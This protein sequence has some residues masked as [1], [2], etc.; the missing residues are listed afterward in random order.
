MPGCGRAGLYAGGKNGHGRWE[1]LHLG[2]ASPG[3][4]LP[5]LHLCSP[6]MRRRWACF[7]SSPSCEPPPARRLL[8]PL[9]MPPGPPLALNAATSLNTIVQDSQRTT[10][11]GAGSGASSCAPIAVTSPSREWRREAGGLVCARLQRM[12]GLFRA[13]KQTEIIAPPFSIHYGHR[14]R[15]EKVLRKIVLSLAQNQGCK[16]LLLFLRVPR[17]ERSACSIAVRCREP[18][19]WEVHARGQCHVVVWTLLRVTTFQ[20]IASVANS[21]RVYESKRLSHKRAARASV[22]HVALALHRSA[23]SGTA[24][25][26]RGFNNVVGLSRLRSVETPSSSHQL[27][28]RPPDVRSSSLFVCV[29]LCVCVCVHARVSGQAWSASSMACRRT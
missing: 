21:D 14:N 7:L 28:Y 5:Q 2:R 18:L 8:R 29:Y 13:Q 10:W 25:A 1:T 4:T 23:L 3:P 19:N 20:A 11:P 17:V 24:A 27:P 9:L 15:T 16:G 26:A 12:V 22:L 6:P